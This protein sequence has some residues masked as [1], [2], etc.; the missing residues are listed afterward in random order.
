MTPQQKKQDEI[1]QKQYQEQQEK[2]QRQLIIEQQVQDMQP[3]FGEKNDGKL[4]PTNSGGGQGFNNSGG[5]QG[6]GR[7]KKQKQVVMS[8]G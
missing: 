5:G 1:N 3:A 7:G 6:K 2:L 4:K 8:W